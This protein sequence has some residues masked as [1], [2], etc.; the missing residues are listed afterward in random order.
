MTENIPKNASA[1]EL[2]I[3]LSAVKKAADLRLGT[4]TERNPLL[5]KMVRCTYCHKRRRQNSPIPCCTAKYGT[6]AQVKDAHLIRYFIGKRRKQ[7]RLSRHRP[8]MFLLR[9]RLLE[10]EREPLLIGP[11]QDSI[12]GL[13][14]FWTPQKEVEPQHLA[15]FVE[16]VIIR[17]QKEKSKKYRD[18]QKLSRKVNRI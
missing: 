3:L 8:P 14:G 11:L 5:G 16:R 4:F 13:P 7:P 6:E 12:E 9:Q 2:E 18:T 1:D 10:L 15:T 17:E